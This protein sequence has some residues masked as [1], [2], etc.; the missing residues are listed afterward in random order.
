VFVTAFIDNAVSAGQG[1]RLRR[2]LT[3]HPGLD[4]L[5]VDTSLRWATVRRLAA[6]GRL[7]SDDLAAEL[8]LDDTAEGRLNH[9][10]ARASRPDPDAKAQAWR[11]LTTDSRLSHHEAMAVIG[12][13][14]LAE[15]QALLRPYLPEMYDSI[16]T[17]WA[18]RA[19]ASATAPLQLRELLPVWDATD[20]GLARSDQ[21]LARP[22]PA[23]LRRVV[24]DLRA[25]QARALRC[26]ALENRTIASGS[27]VVHSS[28][29]KG[30]LR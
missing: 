18:D 16:A 3:G 7:T 11:M 24:E 5:A 22:L 14:N 1:D 26:R 4:G 13:F 17:L 9:L 27:P 20:D 29:K 15:Q 28:T 25:E 12:G 23:S 2:I 19:G 8:A 10:T 21:A 6:L 30:S